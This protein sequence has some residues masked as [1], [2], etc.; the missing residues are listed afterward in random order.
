[1][2]HSNESIHLISRYITKAL[3]GPQSG[4]EIL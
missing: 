3:D 2:G 1:M 4:I